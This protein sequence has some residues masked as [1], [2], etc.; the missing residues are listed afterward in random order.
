MKTFIHLPAFL[1]ILLLFGAS[2]SCTSSHDKSIPLASFTENDVDVSIALIPNTDGDQVI[3]ATFNPPRGYHLYSKD[4]PAMGVD[5]LGRPTLLELSSNSQMKELG[6]LVESVKPQTPDFEPRELLVYPAGPVALSLTVELPEG[7][8]WVQDEIQVT[9]MA[10]SAGQ[11]KPPVVG[12]I[13]PI[14]IPGAETAV[15]Q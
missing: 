13:I 3:T 12:K 9:Y 5:G 7:S 4:I 1:L 11:C 14:R 15:I 8:N 10:C 2:T 6:S